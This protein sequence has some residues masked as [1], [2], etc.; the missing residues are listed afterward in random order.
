M[1][2][3]FIG[4]SHTFFNDMPELFARFCETDGAKPDVTMLAYPGKYLDWHMDE[5]FATRF[6]ILYGG[7]DYCVIQQGAHPF[8]EVESTFTNAKRIIEMCRTAGTVPVI[9]MTWAEKRFPENQAKMIDCYTKLAAETGS[10]L[11]PVGL[12]WQKLQ[13]EH[14]EIELYWKDGEHAS[15]YGDYLIAA[16]DYGV[17]TGKTELDLPP[18]GLDFMKDKDLGKPRRLIEDPAETGVDLDPEKT[19]VILAAVSAELKKLKA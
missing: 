17:I 15:L 4:N 16:A 14:P 9:V 6:N 5:Y 11:S 19:A 2:V 7:Y 18:I 8:P 1:R 10:L 3:L 13:K 12:A